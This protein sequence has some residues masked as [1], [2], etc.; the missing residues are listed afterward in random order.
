MSAK[1]NNGDNVRV[2]KKLLVELRESART[3]LSV[4]Y[5][6]YSKFPVGAA[7]ATAEGRVFQ[8]ANIENVSFGLTICAERT[9]IHQAVLAKSLPIVAIVIYTPTAVPTAP[10]GSCRQV[11]REFGVNAT[12]YSI[13]DSE[14][15]L[16][17]SGDELLPYSFGPEV[18]QSPKTSIQEVNPSK[19]K[20]ICIDIDNVIA[21]TDEVIRGVIKE[22]TGGRVSLKYEDVN[23][24]NYWECIDE[25]GE[26]L[27][28]DEWRIV[29]ERFSEPDIL[30]SIKPVNDVKEC[31]FRLS[32]K[33]TLHFATSRLPKARKSTIEWLDEHGFPEHDIH[34]LK[35]G[36]K[37]IS[38]GPFDISVEDDPE[39]ALAFASAGFG[40]NYLIAH[41]W[42]S[43]ASK[44]RNVKRVSG[45][46][47]IEKNLAETV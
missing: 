28:K 32:E 47:V 7:V 38:L 26:M 23:N 25:N 12:V 45:W 8:G 31:L 43:A 21:Q 15:E 10:C 27:T 36:E 46:E 13:C 44:N 40:V 41:P 2:P 16:C 11:I 19:V 6:P 30:K 42:N 22:V 34:F 35:H 37:H 29:H 20:R 14:K 1:K 4:S 5:C 18:L 24:F 3:A 33:F 9:A 39:Q 17:F